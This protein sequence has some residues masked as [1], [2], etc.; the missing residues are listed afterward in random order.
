MSDLFE[1]EADVDDLVVARADPLLLPQLNTQ[2]ISDY[3]AMANACYTRGSEAADY[4]LVDSVS[5]LISAMR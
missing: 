5:A 4:A 3:L 1:V 2:Q